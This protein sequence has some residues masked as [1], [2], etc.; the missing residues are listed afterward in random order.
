MNR[1]RPKAMLAAGLLTLATT[2]MTAGQGLVAE[3]AL[4]A[5]RS[6][7]S[8]QE[9]EH[10]LTSKGLTRDDRK[11]LLDEGPAITKLHLAQQLYAEYEKAMLKQAQIQ[12]FDEN[13]AGMQ[14]QWQTLQ[15]QATALQQQINSV[16]AVHPRMRAVVNQQLSALRQQHSAVQAQANQ[17]KTQT[18]ALQSQSPKAEVRKQ[19]AADVQKTGQAFFQAARQLESLVTPLLKN[20]HELALDPKVTDALTQLRHETTKN[21]KLGPSDELRAASKVLKDLKLTPKRPVRTSSV[22]GHS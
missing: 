1:F 18:A 13:L 2:K 12:A 9:L 21:Y 22:V 4:Q 20:Y 19:A 3:P 10:F 5:S 8:L 16:G 7:S 6:G 11:F 17:V 15:Q 14:M